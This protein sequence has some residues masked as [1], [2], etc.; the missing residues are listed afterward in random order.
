M[1]EATGSEA[2]DRSTLVNALLEAAPDGTVVVDAEGSIVLVNSQTEAIFGYPRSHLVGQPVEILVPGEQREGHRGHRSRFAQDPKTRLMGVGL[3][4]VGR[5]RDG[6]QIPIEISLSPITVDGRPLTIASVRDVTEQRALQAERD[7]IRSALDASLDGVYLLDAELRVRYAN[8]GAVEQSG[9]IA[10]GLVGITLDQLLPRGTSDPSFE[11]LLAPL[12]AGQQD[13]IIIATRL[14]RTDGRVLNIEA[15]VQRAPDP[16][17][18]TYI[19][20]IRDITARVESERTLRRANEALLLADDRERIARDLHDNVIQRLFASGLALQAS[21]SL[22]AEVART[23]IEDVVE[24]IDVTITELRHAIFELNRA[25]TDPGSFERELQKVTD[26]AARVLGFAPSL[27][28]EVSRDLAPGVAADVLAVLR[29]ALANVVRHARA[30]RVTVGVSDTVAEVRVVVED[31][32]VGVSATALRGSGLDNMN[33][34][35][36][37]LDGECSISARD[38]GGTRIYW[39]VPVG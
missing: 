31:D 10:D 28:V 17:F 30:T 6:R 39:R 2:L 16:L 8:R 38:G 26:D 19:A 9:R 34:R 33:A 3:Q 22:P 12:R 36:Q 14:A 32:G 11:A 20:L 7:H 25:S 27:A 24:G 21:M 15:A 5:H 29:E 37:A 4:L 13:R 23:R 35:A 18:A 1:G